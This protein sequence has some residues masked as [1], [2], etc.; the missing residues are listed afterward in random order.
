MGLTLVTAPTAEPITTTQA[1]LFLRIDT[2]DEDSYIAGCI[3]AAR[4]KVES[5]LDRQL[6]QATYRY[7]AN[8]LINDNSL[9]LPKPPVSAVST[10]NFVDST[11][12]VGT[13]SASDYIAT[14]DTTPARVMFTTVPA[15]DTTRADSLRVTFTAGYGTASS[16]IPGV[17]IQAMYLLL[18][19]YYRRQPDS[20]VDECVEKLVAQ[21]VAWR[22]GT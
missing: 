5:I 14:F 3:T 12:A 21:Y 6:M 8:S 2:T 17:L 16:S 9:L 22:V 19:P 10:V 15:Y 18:E 11:G 7:S 1:K 20:T 4:D 13:V